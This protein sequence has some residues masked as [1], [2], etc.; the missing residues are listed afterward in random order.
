MQKRFSHL[1]PIAPP[2]PQPPLDEGLAA[3]HAAAKTYRADDN[4]TLLSAARLLIQ[5]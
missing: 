2:E 5:H 3:K 1:A 4:G